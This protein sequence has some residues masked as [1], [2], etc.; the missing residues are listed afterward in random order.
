MGTVRELHD[1]ERPETAPSTASSKG[2]TTAIHERWI[3]AAAAA[4]PIAAALLLI[5]W[6]GHL[7]TAD[8]ALILV[9]VIVAVA[10]TGRRL[11]AAL[12]ALVSA[13]AFDF[14]LTRPYYSLRITRTSDLITEILLLVVGLAVGELAARGR[15]HRR[16]ASTGREQVA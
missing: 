8:N 5:P 6:R 14:F 12:S 3:M 1:V 15:H 4:A 9:V 10:S 11:A 2:Q 7:D 13:V 16:A